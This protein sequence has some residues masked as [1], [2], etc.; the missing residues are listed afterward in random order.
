[1][2]GRASIKDLEKRIKNL[3]D[4]VSALGE[5]VKEILDL[6]R[7]IG[8]AVPKVSEKTRQGRK[9]TRIENI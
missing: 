2:A 9:P 3:E 1:L 8:Y 4:R 5:M 6:L 7:E